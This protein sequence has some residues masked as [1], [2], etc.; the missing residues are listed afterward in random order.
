[1]AQKCEYRLLTAVVRSARNP[2]KEILSLL[3]VRYLFPIE[4][5]FQ[6]DHVEL[7]ELERAIRIEFQVWLASSS[8]DAHV[9]QIPTRLHARGI[10]QENKRRKSARQRHVEPLIIMN[11]L[12]KK[13]ISLVPTRLSRAVTA[14]PRR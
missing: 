13:V 14:Q 2:V 9:A 8:F 6:I 1:M 5:L 12:L 4:V 11:V 3:H 10:T 7:D